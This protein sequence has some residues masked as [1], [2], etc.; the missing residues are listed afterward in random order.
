MTPISSRAAGAA[1]CLATF[2]ALAAATPALATDVA[3]VGGELHIADSNA[4]PNALEILPS[5]IG[6][7]IVDDLTDLT[8]GAGCAALGPH[9]VS[10][11]GG[12][13]RIRVASGGGDDVVVLSQ[14]GVPVIAGGG[15]GSDLLEGGINGD[16]LSGGSGQDTLN[17]G[18][19]DDEL[20][21]SGGDDVL[22]GGGG[23][24]RLS[25]GD[26]ADIIQGEAGSGDVLSGND[27]PDLLEG[28]A[29]DDALRGGAGSDVLVTGS[30]TDTATTGSGQ[31]QVF[32]T[33]SDTVTCNP[34]DEVR[35]GDGRPPPGCDKLPSGETK[36][37][38]W[39]P[40]PED[41]TG[42]TPLP[43]PP[44]GAAP[45]ADFGMVVQAARVR[46]TPPKGV[47]RGRVLHHGNART[48]MLQ[49]PSKWDMPIRVRVRT[50][51]RDGRV[52]RT[53]VK[54]IRAKRWYPVRN[55]GAF[56]AAWSAKARCCVQ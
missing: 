25:G 53:F 15:E 37:D 19:G 41:A 26:D 34:G 1:G 5:A 46:V 9:R 31:D 3:I 48:I 23:S 8:P 51:A 50:Y 52:L 7:D 44:A 6:Y 21:G 54:N 4:Q 16:H 24:D 39:P 55:P 12:V 14:V 33:S 11:L 45:I 49:V 47:F 13:A 38:V 28:G 20:I 32:G 35:T 30:G 56:G 43:T 17:G 40:P 42:A 2:L 27:G 22:Q 18:A 29:G 36:P 10:C